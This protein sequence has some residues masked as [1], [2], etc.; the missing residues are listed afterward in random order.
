MRRDN[1]SA[2]WGGATFG[3]LIGVIVGIFAAS[4]WPSVLAGVVFGTC[5]GAGA[6][7]LGWAADLLRAR[8]EPTY[9]YAVSE[10][11]LGRYQRELRDAGIG[12]EDAYIL[13]NHY[14]KTGVKLNDAPS[15]DEPGSL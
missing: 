10:E 6:A 4:F 14:A 12:G 7:L 15:A 9:R 8:R 3:L 13:A 1:R 11:E 2:V 5:L